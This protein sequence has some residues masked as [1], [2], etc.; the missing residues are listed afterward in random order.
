MRDFYFRSYYKIASRRTDR[1]IIFIETQSKL[2][3]LKQG[4]KFASISTFWKIPNSVYLLSPR[5]LFLY[6]EQLCYGLVCDN[7]HQGHWVP[8][9]YC[10]P[11]GGWGVPY[12]S[13]PI[14]AGGGGSVP[15]EGLGSHGHLEDHMI[16]TD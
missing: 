12:S 4:K 9:L 15:F 2:T 11:R 3:L 13:T 5:W 10:H 6:L 14:L 8:I 16:V 1:K 7:Q